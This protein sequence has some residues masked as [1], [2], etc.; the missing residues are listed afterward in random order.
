[1][2]VVS[3]GVAWSGFDLE[4]GG[5]IVAKTV[6]YFKEKNKFCV[7]ASRGKW[8]KVRLLNCRGSEVEGEF[9]SKKLNRFKAAGEL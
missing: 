1:M 4:R 3:E 9:E 5:G 7:F 2:M 8:E 6:E